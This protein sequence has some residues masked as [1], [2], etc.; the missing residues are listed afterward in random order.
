MTKPRGCE[1]SF[2]LDARLTLS[3][4][5]ESFPKLNLRDA[6]ILD[7]LRMDLRD[8]DQRTT[9]RYIHFMPKDKRETVNSIL[10]EF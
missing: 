8:L 1:R 4:N 9:Q 7:P 2:F 10:L 3:T 6:Y 5:L